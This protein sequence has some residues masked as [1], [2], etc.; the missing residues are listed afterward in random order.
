MNDSE[1]DFSLLF[2]VQS[3]ASATGYLSV[4]IARAYIDVVV[5][6]N[7]VTFDTNLD[8][9][10]ISASYNLRYCI[11]GETYMVKTLNRGSGNV[12]NHS[13]HISIKRVK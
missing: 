12:S 7:T 11:A 6:Q 5:C 13:V 9:V 2:G 8:S 10:A 1:Y 3:G 4:A